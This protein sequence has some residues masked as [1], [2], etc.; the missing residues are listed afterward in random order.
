MEIE[1]AGRTSDKK[2][3]AQYGGEQNSNTDTVDNGFK[4]AW[5]SYC[6][7]IEGADEGLYKGNMR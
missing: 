3:N 2:F 5:T 7:G 1:Q 6:N 4:A